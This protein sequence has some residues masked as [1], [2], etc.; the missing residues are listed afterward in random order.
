MNKLNSVSVI[1][2]V[3]GCLNSIDEL[4]RRLEQNLKLV[5]KNYQIIFVD[6]SND[7]NIWNKL[8]VISKI[9]KKITCIKLSR[10]FGQHAAISAG[11]ENC[12]S[13]WVII[14][15]CDLQDRPEE[16]INLVKNC[17]KNIDIVYASRKKRNDSFFKILVSRLFYGLM[18]WLTDIKLDHTVSNFGIYN[19]KTI[20]AVLSLKDR[21]K[22]FPLMV[23]WVGFNSKTILVQHDKR[24]TG[25][26]SY[27]LFKL[28]L[29]SIATIISFSDKSLKIFMFI[30]FIISFLS[31]CVAIYYFY[32]YLN[33]KITVLGYSSLIISIWFIGGILLTAVGFIGIYIG[34][35]FDQTKQRPVYIISEKINFKK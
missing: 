29:I 27:N 5:T 25:K 33:D 18:S 26:S 34:K 20:K 1:I 31:A 7:L 21:H 3:F 16:I 14:M 12:N 13:D 2:P 32:L 30:G 17:D 19:K 24:K 4:Y 10:N 15:D 35:T 9:S 6:D 23:R 28:I 8:K 22:F 11:L